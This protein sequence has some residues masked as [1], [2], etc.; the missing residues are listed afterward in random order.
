M[1]LEECWALLGV[2]LLPGEDSCK[3]VQEPLT[4]PEEPPPDKVCELKSI[5]AWRV[6][7]GR[8]GGDGEEYLQIFSP[9]GHSWMFGFKG[10][11]NYIVI[12]KAIETGKLPTLE[13]TRK[14]KSRM[15]VIGVSAFVVVLMALLSL[16][17]WYPF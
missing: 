6:L 10:S 1:T 9:L 13:Y 8:C 14:K 2:E 3:S 7:Q 12:Q 5:G 11:P 16:V 4:P 17:L 15:T